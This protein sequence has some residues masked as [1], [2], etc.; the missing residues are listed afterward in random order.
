MITLNTKKF[1]KKNVPAH[2]KRCDFR[3]KKQRYCLYNIYFPVRS[4]N[5]FPGVWNNDLVSKNSLY[6][7][8]FRMKNES[9]QE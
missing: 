5:N 7:N 1:C 9:G 6:R 4:R 8:I 2:A 3:K